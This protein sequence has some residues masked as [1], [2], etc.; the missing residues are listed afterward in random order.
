MAKLVTGILF[1]C[2]VTF[3]HH[4]FYEMTHS[5]M[6]MGPFNLI[7]VFD[8]IALY[9]IISGGK[10]V[11]QNIKTEKNG[12]QCYGVVREIKTTDFAVNDNP[13][14]KATIQIVNPETNQLEDFEEVIGFNYKKYSVNSIVLCKY[15]QGDVNIIK[16][17]DINEI[18]EETKKRLIII[19]NFSN[20]ENVVFSPDG[21]YV[22][23]DGV[24][25]KKK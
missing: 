18:P 3:F 1:G 2:F 15:Y 5:L 17:I 25:Y 21:E 19:S 11:I 14:Y 20:S 12:V 16:K 13:E 23:I 9:L 7:Y 10:T 8:A 24:K 22:T 6:L 4:M